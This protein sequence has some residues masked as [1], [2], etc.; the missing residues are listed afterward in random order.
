MLSCWK[1]SGWLALAFPVKPENCQRNRPIPW[2]ILLNSTQSYKF[3]SIIFLKNNII[4]I[5]FPSLPRL[6]AFPEESYG[7]AIHG[8]QYCR[9]HLAVAFVSKATRDLW[10]HHMLS[11]ISGVFH[12]SRGLQTRVWLCVVWLLDKLLHFQGKQEGPLMKK[13]ID[14]FF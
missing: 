11:V 2:Q 3:Y 13:N 6:K 7:A 8:L 4:S 14:C 10:Y 9:S 1:G 12:R 5:S